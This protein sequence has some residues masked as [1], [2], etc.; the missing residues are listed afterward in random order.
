MSGRT[1]PIGI[2]FDTGGTFT[3]C[4]VVDFGPRRSTASRCCRRRQDPS[5]AIFDALSAAGSATA[6][7]AG[8]HPC[9]AARD[10]GRDQRADRAQGVERRSHHDEGLPRRPRAAA[11][12]ALRRGRPVPGIPGAAGAAPLRLGVAERVGADA[13]R[14][15]RRSTRTTCAPAAALDA[16][17]RRS[18]SP[19]ASSTPTSIPRTS[20]GAKAIAARGVRA[21]M[22]SAFPARCSRRSASTSAPARPSPMPTSRRRSG[23][24][25]TASRRP[26]APRIST[27]RCRSCSRT[28][29]L[30]GRRRQCALP[31]PNRRIGARRGDDRGDLSR[32]ARRLRSARQLRHG[33]H[34]GEDRRADGRRRRRIAHEFEVGARASLQGGQRNSARGPERRAHRDRRRRRQ[35]RRTSTAR[36]LRVGPESAGAD[37]GP[38]LLWP[39][40]RR[41]RR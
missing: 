16:A 8:Q 32:A 18:R 17:R 21:S 23:A 38:G 19:S 39:G 28:A 22:R 13:A 41:S 20:C 31:G 2:A 7:R 24:T 33:R 12:D 27:R 3:D 11:R 40:R 36:L 6:H 4:V 10:D 29:A 9:G 14:R 5:I 30:P 25:S 26:A 1:R 37:P 34:D 35:H 15:D